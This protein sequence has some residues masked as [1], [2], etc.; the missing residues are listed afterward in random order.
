[1]KMMNNIPEK[2]LK[3]HHEKIIEKEREINKLKNNLNNK[4]YRHKRIFDYVVI[5]VSVDENVV[6]VKI[7]KNEIEE[8]PL[9]F[10]LRDFFVDE[11]INYNEFFNILN[12]QINPNISFSLF[13]NVYYLNENDECYFIYAEF[14][15]AYGEYPKWK[16][17]KVKF[18][19]RLNKYNPYHFIM[20][21]RDDKIDELA[22]DLDYIN[23]I[24]LENDYFDINEF[25]EFEFGLIKF[26]EKKYL[27]YIE[28]KLQK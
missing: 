10:F 28:S 18:G 21:V 4:I 22:K 14:E 11:K 7:S 1:M 6:K 2:F 26:L 12:E 20:P 16:L 9:N 27:K 13:Y 19:E 24:R 25:K 17:I 8:I 5:P 3:K 15:N 23:Q